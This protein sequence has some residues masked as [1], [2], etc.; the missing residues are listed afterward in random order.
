MSVQKTGSR[1]ASLQIDVLWVDFHCSQPELALQQSLA[2]RFR[3]VRSSPEELMLYDEVTPRVIILDTDV[4]DELVL[5]L[6][7]K[8]KMNFKRSP[9]ILF[10]Q[11][12]SLELALWA[13]KV[14]VWD[15]LSK[16]IVTENLRDI[17]K[18]LENLLNLLEKQSS[19][20]REAIVSH[21][22][23]PK[24]AEG[25]SENKNYLARLRPALDIIQDELNQHL[26]EHVLAK[27][28][29]MSVHHFSRT[30]S[31][32]MGLPLQEYIVRR[33]L[34]EATK[35]LLRSN[36]SISE[37]AFSVGF[38]DPSY[39]S[40]TFKKHYHCSPSQFRKDNE[41]LDEVLFI[42]SKTG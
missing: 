30:F 13:I 1:A 19:E 39:F 23:L 7:L 12:I 29:A 40:R 31:K 26:S 41:Q 16:P 25:Q 32:Q 3:L 33:R 17:L 4:P 42:N 37:I 24:T 9:I 34:E 20:S 8:L 2:D 10:A 15:L 28:C 6:F 11:E 21:V 14:R 35:L 27:S 22:T 36:K 5:R 18:K 38:N